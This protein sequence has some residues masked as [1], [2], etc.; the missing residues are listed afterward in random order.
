MRPRYLRGPDEWQ[1]DDGKQC[2][3]NYQKVKSVAKRILDQ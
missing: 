1:P 3:E 2:L